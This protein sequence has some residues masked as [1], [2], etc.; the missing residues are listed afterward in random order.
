MSNYYRY[1][2]FI[3]IILFL[4][5]FVPISYAQ[6]PTPPDASRATRESD[7]FGS[8]TE[9][10][11]ERELKRVPQKPAGP[12]VET[13][14]PKPGEQKFF[15]KKIKLEGC[16]TFLPEDFAPLVE[17]Y[18]NKDETFTELDNLTK[19]IA[20][21]YLKRGIIAAVF[22]PPQEVQDESITMQVVEA[23]MG[24]LEIQKSPHF[25][26]KMLKYYWHITS[27]EILHYDKI[28]KSLQFMNKNPDREV[29]ASL[30]A[31]EKS[32]TTNVILTPRTS[33]PI[34]GQYT[35]DR[36]GVFMTGREKN[37]FGI[38][39][40]NVLG[41]DDTLITGLSFGKNF[42]GEYIYHS[43]PISGYGASM[44]YGYSYSKSTPKKDYSIYDLKSE[45]ENSTI[46]IHQDI[47]KKDNYMGEVAVGF[48]AKD[49]VTWF[50]KGQ[51]TLNKDNLRVFNINGNF[52]VRGTN[53]V[54]YITPELDQGINAFGAS[55][56]NNPLAS[57][58]GATPDYTKFLL[59]LQN[60]TNLPFNLQQNLKFSTQLAS[61]K[62]FSQ[63]QFGL[64][65]IDTVRGYPSSDYLAD[66]MML[67]NAEMMSPIFLLPKDW[68]LPYAEKPLKEQLTGVVFF[69]YG[70]GEHKG[71]DKPFRLSSVGAGIRM[72]F[73]NQVML[74]LEWGI[75]FKL[76]GQP[77]LTEGSTKGRFH[78]SLSIEDKLPSEI[79][80]IVN[81]MR[82]E[83]KEKEAWAL[84]DEEL[85][86]PGNPISR[87]LSNYTA[88][89]GELYK[90][91]KLK[92]SRQMY[93]MAINLGRSL[94]SQAQDY[95]KGYEAHAAE[96]DKKNDEA[97]ALYKEGKLLEAKKM[98]QDIKDEARPKP[99]EFKF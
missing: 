13:E 22:L 37:G 47:Y 57:R 40:N 42:I 75:P 2:I 30:H 76:F 48:D 82:E 27:G 50:Q 21:E 79:E 83:R 45:A 90:E 77:A 92:E 17:K 46:S 39:D 11:V 16:E 67:L 44:M 99:L 52:I 85:A 7:R 9:K 58:R 93:A 84:I 31:G 38:R 95:I 65:G 53:S 15:V 33:F 41:Y 35:F 74:R 26:K 34:H 62:L 64:G 25:R 72:S 68:K 73:Y 51:G 43:I 10:R 29:R 3:E 87:K 97:L 55:K 63:E 32:G 81:E 59:H 91:G 12:A 80:R 36:E 78:I 24:E 61:Q 56:R 14:K 1:I 86:M 60:R 23:R 54:T 8:A 6:P 19:E 70:Y 18:E 49:K 89:G 88:E 96:L 4:G 5:V 71:E 94:H 98:W 69:D 66:K 28:S 20:G